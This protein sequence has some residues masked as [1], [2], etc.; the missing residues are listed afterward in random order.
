LIYFEVI[1]GIAGEDSSNAWH[2]VVYEG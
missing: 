1:S 2:E